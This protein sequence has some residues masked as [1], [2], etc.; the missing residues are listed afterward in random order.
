MQIH[1][2]GADHWVT[3][4]LIGREVWVYDSL[5]ADTLTSSIDEQLAR[6]YKPFVANGGLLVSRM[7]VQQQ[8]DGFDCGLFS[9]A[10][11][12][13]AAA[14]DNVKRLNFD[15]DKMRGHLVSC[16]SDQKLT[17]FPQHE[18]AKKIVKC[19]L[20]H[21]FIPLYCTCLLPEAYNRHMIQCDRCSGWFHFK[22]MKIYRIP[23]RKWFCCNCS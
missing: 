14:G 3:S 7:P 12:Y 21:I 15:Q 4:Q 23:S 20:K 10:F 18:T 11:A 1:F 17:P 22:C 8:K 6:I 2:T 9:I 5:G 19:S 16:L 13:H